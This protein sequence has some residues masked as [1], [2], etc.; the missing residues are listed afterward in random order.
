MP[1]AVPLWVGNRLAA[2]VACGERATCRVYGDRALRSSES[3]RPALTSRTSKRRL[4]TG[5]KWSCARRRRLAGGVGNKQRNGNAEIVCERRLR[6][7]A[8]HRDEGAVSGISVG[9]RREQSI[10]PQTEAVVSRKRNLWSLRPTMLGLGNDWG[11]GVENG[12]VR[13]NA[14]ARHVPGGAY[15]RRRLHFT[16]G[17]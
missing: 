6:Q 14:I 5:L 8:R 15:N 13:Y 11:C 3:S 12:E 16:H 4:R 1:S 2:F 9:N 7:R 17:E 10:V